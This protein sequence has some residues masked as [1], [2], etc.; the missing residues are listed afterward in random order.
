M[1]RRQLTPNVIAFITSFFVSFF[2][3]LALLLFDIAIELVQPYY[4]YLFLFAVAFVISFVLYK[5]TLMRFVN[6]KLKI[7]YK[8]IGQSLK[9]QKEVSHSHSSNIMRLVEI[10]VGD[11]AINKNKQI[12]ELRKLET[13]RKE[14]VGNVSHEL[15]TPIFNA[16]GYLETLLDGVDDPV[17]EKQYLQKAL[18]NV[19]RLDAIVSDLLEISKFEAGQIHLEKKAFDIIALFH[20][21]FFQYQHIAEKSQATLV[22][23]S[24]FKNL[25]VW[26][27]P[28]RITQVVENL[29]SNAI[30]YGKMEGTVTIKFYI[31]EEQI[32]VE[33]NDDGPG[34]AEENLHRLFERFFRADKSRSRNIGGTGLG[35]SIVKNII[36]AHDQNIT[37]RS[38]LGVGTTFTFTLEKATQEAIDQLNL[39]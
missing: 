19:E 6:D 20:K 9:Y 14:F 26:A 17:I 11:W 36:E 13:Y 39:L 2:S 21:V 34:I 33:V 38:E 3:I 8:A 1:I 22:V 31:L 18:S 15:R 35:L 23:D 29:V 27:D 25:Y 28:V 16:Q 5:F 32:I 37:V 12:R 30:K 10:D 24:K 7:I 4:L